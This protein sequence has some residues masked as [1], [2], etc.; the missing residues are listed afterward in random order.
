MIPS[1]EEPP[2]Q[3]HSQDIE[4][5]VD[6][7]SALYGK[8]AESYDEGPWKRN[9][10]VPYIRMCNVF[11]CTAIIDAALTPGRFILCCFH[12][13]YRTKNTG[14][15]REPRRPVSLLPE[16]NSSYA[17]SNIIATIRRDERPLAYGN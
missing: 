4:E 8:E 5:Y 6:D 11:I 7:L 3:R 13:V 1:L 9:G 15:E 10:Y 16:S 14:F 17:W 12:C 2:D